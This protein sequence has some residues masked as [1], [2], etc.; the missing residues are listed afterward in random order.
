MIEKI[1]RIIY[2][3]NVDK[4]NEVIDY[5]N[6]LEVGNVDTSAF[7]SREELEN[8]VP[9]SA[10]GNE[11]NK[12]PKYSA[13]GHLIF[14]DSTEVYTTDDEVDIP[15]SNEES[16]HFIGIN[17]NDSSDNN[18][19]GDGAIG[20]NSIAI[21]N[22]AET[23]GYSSVAIGSNA[24]VYDDYC[25]FSVAIGCDTEVTAENAIA[26]GKGAK[27]NYVIDGIAIG[28]GAE[29]TGGDDCVAIGNGSI[30][31]EFHEFSIGAP[32]VNG[33]NA[34][35]T[36]RITHVSDGINGT[37]A[38]TLSQMNTAIAT[39]KT[40]YL[41]LNFDNATS[42]LN[43]AGS[44]ASGTCSIAAGKTAKSSGNY[45]L[46][47]GY[48]AEATAFGAIAIG[49]RTNTSS[50][51]KAQALGPGAVALGTN[52]HANGQTSIAIGYQA[53]ADRSTYAGNTDH[54]G[55]AIGEYAKSQKSD[56]ISIG[57]MSIANSDQATTLGHFGYSSGNNSVA[58]GWGST[59]NTYNIVSFG[60][61]P[62]DHH[63]NQYQ[64]EWTDTL[65]RRLV[66]ISNG[67]DNNDAVTVGQL[68]T[69]IEELRQEIALLRQE[70]G[71]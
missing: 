11:A 3:N 30:A 62:G 10:I 2:R 52:A 4:L 1:D 44:G 24:K 46:A 28:Q 27:V 59:A 17:S 48:E 15:D 35:F 54:G 5:V 49:S 43:Y 55:I 22:E 32:A 20:E 31:N 9:T 42:D 47:I 70:L 61:K 19:N 51:T 8:Y 53:I 39:G 25:D 21:G 64:I 18:Y 29:I 57:S 66:N 7:I 40:K 67:I 58:I 16:V 36:R 65:T 13:E 23:Q 69:A 26:I 45:S 6:T 14:P 34:E 41:G 33:G 71:N 38:V 50:E 63:G 60:H 68:N 56:S 37:D 12:I